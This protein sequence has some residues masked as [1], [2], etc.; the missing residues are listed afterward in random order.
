ML[1]RWIFLENGTLEPWSFK[2]FVSTGMPDGQRNHQ[3]EISLTSSQERKSQGQS[4]N[5]ATNDC[6]VHSIHGDFF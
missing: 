2:T 3:A 1:K 6:Y 4:S 5:A